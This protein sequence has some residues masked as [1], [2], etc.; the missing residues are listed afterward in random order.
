MLGRGRGRRYPVPC[1]W[2]ERNLGEHLMDAILGHLYV[3][4]GSARTSYGSCAIRH[5]LRP[6]QRISRVGKIGQTMRV[7][8]AFVR[9]HN[10]SSRLRVPSIKPDMEGS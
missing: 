5:V 1:R 3:R 10:L 4:Q 9:A 7:R 8:A 2:I 6:S